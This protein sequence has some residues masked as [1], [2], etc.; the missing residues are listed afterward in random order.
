MALKSACIGTIPFTLEN[1]STAGCNKF[2][3][4]T[5]SSKLDMMCNSTADCNKLSSLRPFFQIIVVSGFSN[6]KVYGYIPCTLE[7]H[8]TAGCNKFTSPR[9]IILPNWKLAVILIT[10]TILPK[11]SDSR[12]CMGT[13]PCTN[14]IRLRC[15]NIS[16]ISSTYITVSTELQC[17]EVLPSNSTEL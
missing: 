13:I 8:S 4:E 7:N 3:C 6:F 9:S 11:Y 2:S 12:K 14:S 10:E 15:M 1:H 17:R 5:N 16:S